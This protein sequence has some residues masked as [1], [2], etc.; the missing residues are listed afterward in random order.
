MVLRNI[1]QYVVKPV[2]ESGGYGVVIGPHASEKTLEETRERV[3][4]DPGE[5]HRAAGHQPLGASH[6]DHR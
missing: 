5:L 1:E 4:A 6:H 2:G 3:L